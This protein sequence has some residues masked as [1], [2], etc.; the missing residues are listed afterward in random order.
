MK[1][2]KEKYF[3][4][5]LVV[6][7]TFIL[8]YNFFT[9]GDNSANISH[10]QGVDLDARVSTEG[11]DFEE[12]KIY[13][14]VAGEVAFPGLYVF[15]YGVRAAHAIEAAGGATEDSDLDRINLAMILSDGQKVLV[16]KR[17][18]F[19]DNTGTVGE[20]VNINFANHQELCSLP[21]IGDVKAKAIIKYREE[22]GFFK[23]IEDIKK[24]TGIGEAT[25]NS[26]KD[27]ITI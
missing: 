18:M 27:L 12:Q 8:G 19:S 10:L 2:S 5:T 1:F 11:K 21:G 25:F 3:L 24:V 20:R 16:P 4:A 17:G 26:I 14:H 15:A 23:S 7:I 13:V 9:K 6:L 22:S